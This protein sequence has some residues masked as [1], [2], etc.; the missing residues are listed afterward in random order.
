MYKEDIIT[1]GR[2]AKAMTEQDMNALIARDVFVEEGIYSFEEMD[3]MTDEEILE[4]AYTNW[5]SDFLD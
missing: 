1:E 3:E 4:E 2:E 5:G